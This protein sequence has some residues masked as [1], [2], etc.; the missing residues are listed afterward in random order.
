MCTYI[1]KNM[2]IVTNIYIY[3]NV[4]FLLWFS[5]YMSIDS[6]DM[7]IQCQVGRWLKSAQQNSAIMV[8]PQQVPKSSWLSC[9]CWMQAHQISLTAWQQSLHWTV[10]CEVSSGHWR[11]ATDSGESWMSSAAQR[12]YQHACSQCLCYQWLV[13]FFRPVSW[14]R[15]NSWQLCGGFCFPD[16]LLI[17][18]IFNHYYLFMPL[19]CWPGRGGSELTGGLVDAAGLDL[20]LSYFNFQFLF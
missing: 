1:K 3:R 8:C 6:D 12:W 17:F 19:L 11:C 7:S 9:K 15:W 18:F 14:W 10:Q 2:Y 13:F 5:S 4:L 20:F 16:F